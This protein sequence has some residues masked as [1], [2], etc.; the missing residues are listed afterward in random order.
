[1]ERS[2]RVKRHLRMN[3]YEKDYAPAFRAASKPPDQRLAEILAPSNKL[4]GIE[5]PSGSTLSHLIDPDH[6]PI[7]DVRTVEVLYEANRSSSKQ[8]NLCQL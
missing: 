3:R 1:M 6:V 2:D 7:M 4:P 8:R 5:A